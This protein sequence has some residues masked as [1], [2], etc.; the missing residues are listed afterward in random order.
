MQFSLSS[1][2]KDTVSG[3]SKPTDSS[4]GHFV[5]VLSRGPTVA[6]VGGAGKKKA[7][8]EDIIQFIYKKMS[9]SVF[10]GAWE[11]DLGLSHHR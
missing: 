4:V 8:R 10:T 3:R 11:R 2:F 1:T 6:G 9:A 5:S 7:L